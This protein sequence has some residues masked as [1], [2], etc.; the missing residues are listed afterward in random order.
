MLFHSLRSKLVLGL[1]ALAC[2]TL[3]HADA[4]LLNA[5]YDVAREL[6]KDVNVA[7]IKHWR[8]KA[9]E[10]LTIN[11]SHAGSSK[12]ALSVVAGLEADVVTMN[13][14]NDIDLLAERGG[15]VPRDWAK[16][17]PYGSA[18]YTTTQVFIVRKGNPKKIRDWGD[19]IKPGV[20][21]I[22][23]NPKVT[24]NGRYTYLAAW[25]W[26]LKQGG[27]ARA[28]DTVTKLF[29][30]VPILDGGGRA[31]TTTFLQRNQGD[32]LVTFENEALLVARE[33]GSEQV[34]I[35]YPPMSILAEPPVTVVDKV[36]D[37]RGTRKQ[38]QAYLEF[39]YSEEGQEIIAR[40]YLRPRSTVF[41]KKYAEQFKPIKMVTV[42]ELGGW[43]EV[44]KK[45]FA[46][47][48]LFDQIY[49][50]KK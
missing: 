21:V 41:A 35:V 25:A 18:P 9:G 17:L 42:D 28:R 46:D 20:A 15:L 13:Q 16:R 22:A 31:A 12:Q 11:Q 26:G 39:L 23:P 36:V 6:Y 10:T 2:T 47:G 24:G 40:H 43:Q 3:A 8:A 5:S 29:R 14:S 44:Q 50:E 30:N 37:K 49:A 7:F 33:L 4:T 1:T 19:L 38:A 27:E 45:H 32:V 48:G 34:E